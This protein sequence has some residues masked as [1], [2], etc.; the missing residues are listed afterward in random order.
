MFR[1]SL[2]IDKEFAKYFLRM[3]L[4]FLEIEGLLSVVFQS[5]FVKRVV[6]Y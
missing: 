1:K 3:V 2:N 6:A 5:Y 4:F